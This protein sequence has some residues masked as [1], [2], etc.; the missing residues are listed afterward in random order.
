MNNY[1]KK[2]VFKTGRIYRKD[3]YHS[4]LN[5]TCTFYPGKPEATTLP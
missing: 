3:F 2:K 5:I 4:A 1:Y